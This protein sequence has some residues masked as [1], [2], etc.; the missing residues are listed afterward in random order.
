MAH[1]ESS[2]RRQAIK[3]LIGG[4]AAAL[5]AAKRAVGGALTFLG[6]ESSFV[7]Q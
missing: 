6:S 4:T 3:H 7:T 1:P 5:R 2:S